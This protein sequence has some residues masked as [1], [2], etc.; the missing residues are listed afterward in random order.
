MSE[1]RRLPNRRASESFDL[2]AVTLNWLAITRLADFDFF[3]AEVPSRAK[4]TNLTFQVIPSRRCGFLYKSRVLGTGRCGGRYYKYLGRHKTA[5]DGRR[6][7][8]LHFRNI[9]EAQR[10]PR[11][12]PEASTLL[13]FLAARG[14]DPNDRL[15]ADVRHAIG[16]PN[17][18][19]PGFGN[20]IKD[21]G[22]PLDAA[23]EA[24]VQEGFLYDLGWIS[25]APTRT[26]VKDLLAAVDFELRGERVYRHGRL[27]DPSR[28]EIERAEDEA[29]F[30]QIDV[31]PELG[32]AP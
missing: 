31:R 5:A 6:A 24:A 3:K 28:H 14:L 12:R 22:I 26:Y 27:P 23:R 16:R 2:E 4:L 30:R 19:I 1:R 32:G 25:D 11:A 21:G 29:A 13:Q 20:L 9:V 15:I 10:R 17:K 7:C 18:Y 8:E